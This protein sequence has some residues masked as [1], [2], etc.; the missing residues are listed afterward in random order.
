[1]PIL[2][3]KKPVKKHSSSET[4]FSQEN[5]LA[6]L[7]LFCCLLISLGTV[8]LWAHDAQANGTFQEYQTQISP[9]S[10]LAVETETA[11]ATVETAPTSPVATPGTQTTASRQPLDET[12]PTPAGAQ[13]SLILVGFVLVGLV[14]LA[15][16]VIVRRR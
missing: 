6:Q 16:L 10:P 2:P 1:M 13:T 5:V 11:T 3:A 15:V 9:I 14:V 4:V 7:A 8:L 12:L